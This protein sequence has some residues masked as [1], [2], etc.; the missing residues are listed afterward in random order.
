MVLGNLLCKLL[1]KGT[2]G[3]TINLEILPYGS[4]VALGD[5]RSSHYW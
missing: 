2:F 4:R 1:L 3:L 5:L